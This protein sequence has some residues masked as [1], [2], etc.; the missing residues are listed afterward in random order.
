MESHFFDN[1]KL[2]MSSF[3]LTRLQQRLENVKDQ[4]IIQLLKHLSKA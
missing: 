1:I 2:K 3:Q 4:Q